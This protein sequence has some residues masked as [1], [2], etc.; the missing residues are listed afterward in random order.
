MKPLIIRFNLLL[1]LAALW[2]PPIGQ[3]GPLKVIHVSAPEIV[4]NFSPTC[5]ITVNDTVAEFVTNLPAVSASSTWP[6]PSMSGFLQSRTFEGLAGTK[7]AGHYGYEYRLDLQNVSGAH[8]VTLTSLTIQFSPL[9][10]FD[11]A[12][13]ANN[14]VW[15]CT[16]G[17]LGTVGPSS[18]SASGSAVTF[19]FNPPITVLTGQ[20]TST[21]FFGLVSTIKPPVAANGWASFTGSV[22]LNATVT[23]PFNYLM[24]QVRT[25]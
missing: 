8:S 2:L 15:V 6:R 22:Q 17:G 16:S 9:S 4:C 20:E 3:C 24:L 5:S 25:P 1:T 12:G 13:Q 7:E 10:S 23:M 14:D 11:Y 18:A 21:F 19:E